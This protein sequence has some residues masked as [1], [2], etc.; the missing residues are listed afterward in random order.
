MDGVSSGQELVW[1]YR[2]EAWPLRELRRQFRDLQTHFPATRAAKFAAFNFATR[3]FGLFADPEFRLLRRLGP[4]GLALDVGGNWGQSVVALQRYARPNRIVTLEPNPLLAQHL[5]KQ[6]ADAGNV[7]VI[8]MGL[9]LAAGQHQMHVPRYRNYIYDGIASLDRDAA[10]EWLN[11]RRIARFSSRHLSVDSFTVQVDRLDA[12]KLAP[13]LIKIDVQ[14]FE[15]QV[16]GGGLQTIADHQPILIIERPDERAVAVLGKLGLLPY[17]WN[18]KRLV[19]GD[20]TRK[21]TM[22]LAGRHHALLA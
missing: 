6:F 9:G 11:S 5:R 20:L 22:F 7:D 4:L 18:G 12:L 21:N 3:R 16:I 15:T 17:G 14:G 13:D 1:G 8:E 19:E 2:P 10:V